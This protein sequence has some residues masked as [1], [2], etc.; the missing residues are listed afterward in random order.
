MT[1][2]AGLIKKIEG[3][4]HQVRRLKRD[5]NHAQLDLN[6]LQYVDR[7]F[8]HE[9]KQTHHIREVVQRACDQWE[10]NVTEPEQDGHSAP[11]TLYIK[12]R[13]GLGW[14]W[15][16]DYTKNGQFA[17]CGA[18]AAWCYTKVIFNIRQKIFPSCYRM[19]N[20][21]GGTSRKVS[22]IQK[23]DIVV[24]YT[25]DQK[26][27]NYGNHITIAL[28]TPNDEGYFDT[29]EGNAVGMGPNLDIR[30]GV[31]KRKRSIFNVAHI[32]RLRDEDFDE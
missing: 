32:Y 26:T 29:V 6:P 4:E 11:I 19:Y 13:E 1:T 8:D 17:W 22:E 25:S 2:K 16:D 5:V 10:K 23:G 18:F 14:S 28:S 27:P 31:I 3:L 30:E 12:S 20:A 15:E 9:S 7:C 24:V 21:W